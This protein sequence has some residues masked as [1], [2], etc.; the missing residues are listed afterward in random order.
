MS[1]R[2]T[3]TDAWFRC[4]IAPRRDSRAFLFGKDQILQERRYCMP[5]PA[6]AETIDELAQKLRDSKGA[7]LL[8]YRGLNVAAITRLRRDLSDGDV[9][10]QV[11]KNTLLRI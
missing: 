7:V 3:H 6:K 9:E 10:F 11:A 1:C 8:N 4:V 5:T 2:G